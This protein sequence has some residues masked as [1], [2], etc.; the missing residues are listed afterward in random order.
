VLAHPVEVVDVRCKR[1]FPRQHSISD[2]HAPAVI[3]DGRNAF[4]SRSKSGTR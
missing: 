2:L 4:S 1:D 3:I